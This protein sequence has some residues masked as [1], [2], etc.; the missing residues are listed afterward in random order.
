MLFADMPKPAKDSTENPA[1]R[2]CL[3]ELIHADISDF[4]ISE[5]QRLQ[6]R[7]TFQVYESGIGHRAMV[8]V[9]RSESG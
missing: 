5:V 9:Q 7:Q 8:E 6:P 3:F 4:G 1:F 2:Q